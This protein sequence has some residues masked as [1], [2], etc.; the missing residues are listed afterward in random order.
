MADEIASE[1]VIMDI[2]EYRFGHIKVDGKSFRDDIKIIND[3]VKPDWW[4]KAGH[5]VETSDVEDVLAA[6]PEIFVLG[7]GASGNVRVPSDF[8]QKLEERGIELI[9]QP[10]EQAV[11]TFE[12]LQSE[13]RKVAAGFHL[14]C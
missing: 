13:G 3:K 6:E 1:A 14:T 11:K 4:R 10:T 5:S 9:A 8:R 7:T 2:Q 12:K